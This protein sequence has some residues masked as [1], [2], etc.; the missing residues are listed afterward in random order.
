MKRKSLITF[1]IIFIVALLSGCGK[2]ENTNINPI[3]LEF[4]LDQ[5][6]GADMAELDYV[7]DDIVI[8]HGYFGMFVY[9]LNSLEITSS[10]DLKPINCNATQGDNYCDVSVSMDGNIV[11]LHEMSSDNMFVYN[12]INHTLEKTAYKPMKDS[13]GSQFVSIEEVIDSTM[14]GNHSHSAV[15]L[16][17][18]EYGYLYAHDGTIGSLTYVQGDMVYNIFD[19]LEQD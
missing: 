17:S 4:H 5:D 6:I 10:L 8:F 13:F 3:S 1:N 15:L 12:V 18:G 16:D 7:S 9:D 11:Q 19:K 2:T 14:L